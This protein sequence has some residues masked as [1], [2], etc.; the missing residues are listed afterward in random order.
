[1]PTFPDHPQPG[2]AARRG[3]LAALALAAAL[4]LAAPT[5][6]AEA[7]RV[8][9][10]AVTGELRGPTAAEAAA[11]AKAEA[12]LRASKGQPAVKTPVEITYPDG[13]VETKLDEDSMMFS[14]VRENGDGTLAMACLPAKEAKAFVKGTKKTSAKA[15]AKVSHAHQ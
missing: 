5:H 3:A 9:R 14:V 6:A 10:D 2:S 11:F 8:V 4:G 13:T 15:E 1:M 7:L 12:A